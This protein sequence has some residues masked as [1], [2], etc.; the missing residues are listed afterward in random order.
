MI[1][2]DNAGHDWAPI[3]RYAFLF[4]YARLYFRYA[5]FAP[6]PRGFR[7][8]LWPLPPPKIAQRHEIA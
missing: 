5:F 8:L 3:L 2:A 4:R 1:D 7:G 6:R